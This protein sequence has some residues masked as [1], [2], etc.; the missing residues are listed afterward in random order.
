MRMG[1]EEGDMGRAGEGD[2]ENSTRIGV[3]GSAWSRG[4]LCPVLVRD[5]P[6]KL[7]RGIFTEM[8][9]GTGG[10]EEARV[11]GARA[12]PTAAASEHSGGEFSVAVDEEPQDRENLRANSPGKGSSRRQNA[13]V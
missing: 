3:L 10:G 8:T 1:E 2:G 7:L 9:A 12:S 4:R 5:E 13:N 11:A 6:A